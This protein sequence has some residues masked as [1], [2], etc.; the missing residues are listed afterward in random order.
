MPSFSSAVVT[1]NAQSPTLLEKMRVQLKRY[2]IERLRATDPNTTDATE[3]V[4]RSFSTRLMNGL[5]NVGNV[6]YWFSFDYGFNPDSLDDEIYN[7]IGEQ[8]RRFIYVF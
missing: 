5:I 4:E 1:T 3:R 8:W 7:A 2:A 6:I